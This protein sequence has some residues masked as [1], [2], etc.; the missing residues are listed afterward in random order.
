MHPTQDWE[1]IA[2]ERHGHLRLKP[3]PHFGHSR[4]DNFAPL[5]LPEV[6]ALARE[7]FICFPNNQTD[8]PHMLLGFRKADNA[9][10]NDQGQWLGHYVPAAIR[11]Y[12]FRLAQHP[13]AAADEFQ[14]VLDPKAAVLSPQDTK[15]KNDPKEGEPLFTEQGQLSPAVQARIKLLKAFELQARQTQE[16]VRLIERLGLFDMEKLQIKKDSQQLAGIGGLRMVNEAR[17][18]ALDGAALHQLMQA[19]ALELLYA[20]KLSKANLQSGILFGQLPKMA[21]ELPNQGKDPAGVV[22][23]FDI[24]DDDLSFSFH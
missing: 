3:S 20:H 22:P 10:V 9:Y 15:D 21:A 18:Q 23:L 16:A 24:G 6:V 11:R 1:V 13:D 2:Q 5:V 8:L 14:V 12:P 17:L 19:G 4:Y 7:A